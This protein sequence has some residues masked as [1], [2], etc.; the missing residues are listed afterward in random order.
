MLPVTLQRSLSGP[1]NGLSVGMPP[2]GVMR[3]ILP[4]SPPRSRAASFTR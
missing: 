4:E 1:V 2:D 3:K